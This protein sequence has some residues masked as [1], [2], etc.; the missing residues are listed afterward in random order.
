MRKWMC[1]VLNRKLLLFMNDGANKK[2]WLKWP[3]PQWGLDAGHPMLGPQQFIWGKDSLISDTLCSVLCS[4]WESSSF[5]FFAHIAYSCRAER[6]VGSSLW[7][8]HGSYLF[9]MSWLL[10]CGRGRM[11]SATPTTSP[12]PSAF[13][14]P[15]PWT[16]WGHQTIG[17]SSQG[18]TTHS[19]P[20]CSVIPRWEKG[21]SGDLSLQ[22]SSAVLYCW[23]KI[24]IVTC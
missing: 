15:S 10:C 23:R 1:Q 17:V 6:L 7:P 5:S 20:Y 2:I 4:L 24:K 11:P 18:C 16:T 19:S 14:L 3:S 22:N 12:W 9:L 13:C 21:T 8:L